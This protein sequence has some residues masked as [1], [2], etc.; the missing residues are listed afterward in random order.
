[1]A[2]GCKHKVAQVSCVGY[3]LHVDSCMQVACNTHIYMYTQL[4]ACNT[5]T[6]RQTDRQTE[7]ERERER[8]SMVHIQRWVWS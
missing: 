2:F 8:E 1:M 6:H 5:H 4:A 3:T 7:R